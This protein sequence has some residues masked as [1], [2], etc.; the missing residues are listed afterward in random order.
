MEGN[1]DAIYFCHH[2]VYPSIVLF[3][4]LEVEI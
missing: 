1:A 4:F 3:L 2:A